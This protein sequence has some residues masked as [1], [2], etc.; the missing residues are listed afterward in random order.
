M[1]EPL[2]STSGP[3]APLRASSTA[4]DHLGMVEVHEGLYRHS[5]G[6]PCG[7]DD[8]VDPST[9]MVSGFSHR[10]C[11]P[12][13]SARMVQGA[14]RWFGHGDGDDIDVGIS[15]RAVV[16]VVDSR[17]PVGRGEGRARSSVPAGHGR[18]ARRAR[19][20]GWH[21][22]GVCAIR[23]GPMIPQRR[24]VTGGARTDGTRSRPRLD[25]TETMYD[26]STNV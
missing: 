12:A 20:P 15:I 22:R 13:S 26:S 10:T 5:T 18:R 23:P 17:D 8:G 16:R 2:T 3:R 21:G 1:N 14:C 4:A 25:T 19:S 6:P 9:V 11:L 24:D 7:L